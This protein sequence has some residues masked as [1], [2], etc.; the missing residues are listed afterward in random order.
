MLMVMSDLHFADTSSYSLGNVVYNHNLPSGVYKAYFR[1]I[2]EFIREDDVRS[3]DLVLAGDI[4]EITR[5]SIW[6][7]DT[8]RPYVHLAEVTED[9][10]IEKRIIDILDAIAA[11]PRVSETLNI[12]R[13]LPELFQVPVNL[14]FI[15]GNHD[16]L[17]NA[18]P[19]IRRRVQG[20]LGLPVNDAPF[21]N[22]YVHYTDGEA[23]VLVRHGNE[24]DPPN[25]GTN[26]KNWPSIPTFIDKK[27][28]DMPT[29]G[30]IVTAEVASK[31]PLLFKEYYTV[32]TIQ[33]VDELGW[34]YQR[35]IDFDNV[36]PVNALINFLFSTPGLTKKQV[37]KYIEPVF[38]KMLD[39][40]ALNPN[41]S[42]QILGYSELRGFSGRTLRAIIK[43]RLWRVGMPF[44]LF[45]YLVAPLFTKTDLGSQAKLI[46]KEECLE[47][48]ASNV[49]CIVAG[50]THNPV[51]ELLSV[52]NG[53]E[54]YYINSGT[55]RNV[56]TTTP[57]FDNFGRLRSK[58]RVLV[59]A[60]GERDPEY[61]RQTGWSFDFFS[62]F[63]YGSEP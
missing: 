15:P 19:R 55:F 31:L 25:F 30:D 46:L 34:I 56:I 2:V 51:V 50:H 45:K 4:F 13:N 37:W 41:V 1:E 60:K 21:K 27:Y 61:S 20:F 5:S 62:K 42:G 23:K 44:W 22:Q 6:H 35:L 29:L 58:S 32:E 11:D 52:D 54:E 57:G 47:P 53:E 16:R 26:I 49:K 12:F 48:G 24:Y 28:Y 38:L 33:S 39:D 18:T 3:I 9:S 17:L 59:F 10:E 7:I 63:A 8:L 43:T 14:H 40:I 36:R